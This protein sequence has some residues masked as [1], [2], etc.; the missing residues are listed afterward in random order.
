MIPLI[1]YFHNSIA[2]QVQSSLLA[3]GLIYSKRSGFFAGWFGCS[4]EFNCAVPLEPRGFPF[5]SA[6][7]SGRTV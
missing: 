4:N 1:S 7:S 6:L 5:G 3:S 2:V